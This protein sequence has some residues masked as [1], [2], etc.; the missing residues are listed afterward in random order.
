MLLNMVSRAPQVGDIL[1]EP[2]IPLAHFLS[3]VSAE[4]NLQDDLEDALAAVRKGWR[5]GEG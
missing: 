1:P 2:L 4:L 3:H 5:N